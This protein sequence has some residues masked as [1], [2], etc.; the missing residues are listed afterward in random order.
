MSIVYRIGTVLA[1]TSIICGAYVGARFCLD[2][3]C[4]GSSSKQRVDAPR[5]KTLLRMA[6]SSSATPSNDPY[7]DTS[8]IGPSLWLVPAEPVRAELTGLISEISSA[9]RKPGTRDFAVFSPH[10]TVGFWNVDAD[11]AAIR[12]HA[13]NLS[14][15][16]QPFD[17]VFERAA[18]GSIFF[19]C[20]YAVCQKDDAVMRPNALTQQQFGLS[21]DYMPHLSLAYADVAADRREAIAASVQSSISGRVVRI[22]ALELWD[23]SGPV[24]SWALV[25][26]FPL[27]GATE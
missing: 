10:I 2:N 18:V 21:Y 22:D 26:R 20:V 1:L 15:S 7:A 11:D 16:A 13:A 9:H 25:Q 14:V 12:A 3:D 6:A 8:R 4:T 23:T 24:D 27:G 19:Q 5:S 17:V